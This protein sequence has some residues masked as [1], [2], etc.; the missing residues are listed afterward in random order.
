MAHKTQPEFVFAKLDG[1]EYRDFARQHDIRSFPTV[2]YFPKAFKGGGAAL[3]KDA[4]PLVTKGG[5]LY[6]GSLTV[7]A[8][9]SFIATS[10]FLE[11]FK[12]PP[13]PPPPET[14][15]FGGFSSWISSSG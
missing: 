12:P 1:Y 15:Y 14:S 13:P 5:E 9:T 8:L 6:K 3:S 10:N 4:A 7:P 2:K 11:R